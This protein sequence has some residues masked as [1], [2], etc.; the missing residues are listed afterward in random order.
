MKDIE[1][2]GIGN[3]LVDILLEVS[4]AEFA[5]FGF[6]RSTMRLVENEEQQKLL[7]RL[8]KA[9]GVHASGGSVANSIIAFAQLG[10]KGALIGCVGEDHYGAFYRDELT[11]LG[12]EVGN[13][14]LRGKMTGTSVVMV[15][16]D[17]ERTM[18]TCL[19]AAAD[20][21]AAHVDEDRIARSQWLF[22]EGYLFANPHNGQTA[23][24]EAISCAKK[25]GTKIAVTC[26]E[27]FVVQ[28]F[29]D[30]LQ[31]ALADTALLFANET[32]ASALAALPAPDGEKAFDI[33]R[34]RF[35]SVVVTSGPKGA[36]ISHGGESFHVEA[37]KC[38][39]V[40]LTG[41]GDMFAGVMLYGITHQVE[42]KRSARAACL[43]CSK[44]ISQVGARLHQGTRKLWEHTINESR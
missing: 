14:V 43:L 35:P 28:A 39:P 30:A 34:R 33:L 32:E 3:A 13:P 26:S 29:G 15:T 23:I 1:V 17:A 36:Y 2:C 6:E 25:H 38:D 9:Q 21:A 22:I 31:R 40:D 7:S 18:R 19:A 11:R 27:A 37:V 16:P 12:I 42:L 20:L 24:F 8:D 4:D 41:A 44:V 5:S 10:G